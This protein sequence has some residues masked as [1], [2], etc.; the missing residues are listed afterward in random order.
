MKVL[1]HGKMCGGVG[2][3]QPPEEGLI[4]NYLGL[5]LGITVLVAGT[6]SSVILFL[7][8]VTITLVVTLV[9]VVAMLVATVIAAVVPMVVTMVIA[10]AP[11][12]FFWLCVSPSSPVLL[13][14]LMVAPSPLCPI[15]TL[16]VPVRH[17]ST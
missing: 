13:W 14:L 12:L 9:V 6:S 8:S 16:F 4:C 15:K 11:P 1:H 5:I 3:S 2:Y 7:F 10:V 17:D